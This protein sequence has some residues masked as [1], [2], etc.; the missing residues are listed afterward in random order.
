MAASPPAKLNPAA[1][2]FDGTREFLEKEIAG[3]LGH[4]CAEAKFVDGGIAVFDSHDEYYTWINQ[5]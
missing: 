3:C 2:R 4:D 1:A 5:K